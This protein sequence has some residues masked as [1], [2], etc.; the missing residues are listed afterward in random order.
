MSYFSK[1]ETGDIAQ[2][3]DLINS[4]YRGEAAKKG[5]THEADL[6][7]GDIRTDANALSELILADESTIL[8]YADDGV[9]KGCVYLQKQE[10]KMYLGMLTVAP[11]LQGEG[12][13]KQLLKASEDFSKKQG[14]NSIIMNVIT[15]RTKLIDWYVK[16][17]YHVT[18]ERKPFP[19]DSPFGTPVKPLEFAILKKDL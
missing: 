3:V 1:A 13:G 7:K 17:G 18:E 15:E 6:I 11:A 16:Y 5:W 10:E 8:K 12:I 2:L 9:L 19:T 14:C 4:A